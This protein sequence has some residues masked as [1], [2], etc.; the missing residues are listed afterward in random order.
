M[1][2]AFHRERCLR[3]KGAGLSQR[4]VLPQQEYSQAFVVLRILSFINRF[5]GLPRWT[6]ALGAICL[7]A[8]FVQGSSSLSAADP[9]DRLEHETA[10]H[11]EPGSLESALL[12]FSRQSGIQV[13]VS[14]RVA[15]ISVTAIEGRRNAREVLGA[16]LNATGLTFAIVGDTVTVYPMDPKARGT[17]GRPPSGLPKNAPGQG[18]TTTPKPDI[19]P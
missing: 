17:V 8:V 11:I 4:R 6:S 3:V 1:S 12:Q 2:V 9:A 14:A 19:S 10:F 15:N 7:G 5:V 18:T 13:V 16:L